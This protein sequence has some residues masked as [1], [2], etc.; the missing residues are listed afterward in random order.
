MH[1]TKDQD[2]LLRMSLLAHFEE[3]R[4]R[5]IRA[6][7]GFGII[8]LACLAFSDRLWLIV[9]APAVDAFRKLGTGGLVGINAMEQFEIIWM[10]TP[11]VAALFL[12]SPWIFYQVWAF[13]APGLYERERKWAIPFVLTTGGLFILGGLFAYFLAFRYGL[14][15][16]L[17]IGKFAGVTTTL[18]IDS[19]F[20]LFVDVMLGVSLIFE[21]PVV[22]F[23]LV[24][25]RLATPKFLWEHSRYAVLGIIIVASFITPTTDVVNMS[26]FA[27]PMCLLFFAGVFAGYLLVLHREQRRFPWIKTA[28]WLTVA[29][30]I[31]GSAGWIVRVKYHYRPVNHWPFVRHTVTQNSQLFLQNDRTNALMSKMQG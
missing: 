8:F 19:Y 25:L 31:L 26:L 24:L 20:D 15:F 2:G 27:V 13:I 1:E 9:Q 28:L 5:L 16:L 21:I 22:I 4:S 18:S 12:G 14:T 7:A 10:W 11:L 23:F 30:V 3:L 6:L 29:L 17:G